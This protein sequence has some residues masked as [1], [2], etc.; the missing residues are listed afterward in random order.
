[1]T[2]EDDVAA[3]EAMRPMLLGLAYRI[4]GSR[5]EAEDAVQDTFLKWQSAD[6]SAIENPAS[7]L[8]TLCTRRCIDLLRAAR[9]ARVDYVGA[10]LPEPIHA[11]TEGEPGERLSL[12]ASL[13]TAFLL[14]L[15]RLTPKERAAYLLHEVFDVSYPEIAATLGLQETTC[16]KLVSRARANVAQSKVRHTTPLDRQEQLLAAFQTAVTSGGTEQLS[17][18]LSD[19]VELCADGG[20][21]V[22]TLREVLR[23]RA[24]VLEFVGRA[25]HAYWGDYTWEATDING[26]RGVVLWK[27]GSAV[28]CVSFAYDE[29]GAATNVYIVRNP[30]KLG[31][32][33]EGGGVAPGDGGGGVAPGGAGEPG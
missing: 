21:K 25:L 6:R 15:E 9:N 26:G 12:A 13:Q 11:S 4:L 5:A 3:F 24:E 18:L 16:R 10:W 20:G 28:A 32:L 27:D 31:R 7:W 29:Q 2:Q 22:P 14:V 33:G 23:G 8:T 17:A 1:M 30:D 19:E